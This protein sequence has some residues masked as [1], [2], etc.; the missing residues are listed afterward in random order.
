[1]SSASYPYQ[2]ISAST[3]YSYLT[4]ASD[5]LPVVADYTIPLG[6]VAPTASF[7]GSP[8]NGAAP[9]SVTFTNAT[10]T[11]SITNWYWNF[12]DGVTTNLSTNLV[13]HTYATGGGYSVTEVVSGPGGTA[14]NTQANYITVWAVPV[15]SFSAT[16]TTG[17][18][19]LAVAF[20][21]TSSGSITNWFWNFGDGVTTNTATNQLVHTYATGGVYSVT[22]IV[23]GPGGAATNTQPNAVTVWTGFQAWQVQYFGSTNSA[24]ASALFDA[25]GTG[26]DNYFKYVA[27]L[28]PTNPASV[29]TWNVGTVPGQQTWRSLTFGPVAN[30]RTY[31][32]Q[33]KTDLVNGAWAPLTSYATPLTTNGTQVTITDTNAVPAMEFYRIGISYP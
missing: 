22:E 25:S 5:H 21:D 18:A 33:F 3:L 19:A 32:P 24:S 15:A 12:G 26:Q 28:N 7:S 9:L 30:G 10:S 6:S 4:T 29:F 20:S 8:T 27:G 31:I 2:Y 23:S 1:M 17:V 11:G 13:V 14:T 16:P